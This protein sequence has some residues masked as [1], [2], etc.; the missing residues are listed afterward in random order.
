MVAPFVPDISKVEP[1]SRISMQTKSGHLVQDLL[2]EGGEAAAAL[3]RFDD[4]RVRQAFLAEARRLVDRGADEVDQHAHVAQRI[5]DHH[6]Q[7][8][9][10]GD[11]QH[12]AAGEGLGVA[13]LGRCVVDLFG[14]QAFHLLVRRLR[15]LDHQRGDAGDVLAFDDQAH[16]P[17]GLLDQAPAQRVEARRCRCDDAE[18]VGDVGRTMREATGQSGM[19]RPGLEVDREVDVRMG[20]GHAQSSVASSRL[21]RSEP[22]TTTRADLSCGFRAMPRAWVSR[23]RRASTLPITSSS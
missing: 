18:V 13:R 21:K 3:D 7:F 14:R 11:H 19:H 9:A 1:C 4:D 10:R 12:M 15:K 16:R 8:P 5:A 6:P 17:G 22:S 23:A 2:A 20:V